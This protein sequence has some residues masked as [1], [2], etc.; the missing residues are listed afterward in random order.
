M[1]LYEG[2][3]PEDQ[4]SQDSQFQH[5]RARVGDVSKIKLG[6]YI[7][8]RAPGGIIMGSLLFPGFM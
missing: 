1:I 3:L 6:E 5:H 2:S 4:K 7:L 8:G